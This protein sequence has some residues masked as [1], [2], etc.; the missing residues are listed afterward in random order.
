MET[1]MSV[2]RKIPRLL[3][4]QKGTFRLVSNFAI[5]SKKKSKLIKSHETSGLLSK[6]EIRTPSSNIAKNI[7]FVLIKIEV[8]SLK[9]IKWL[10][11]LRWLKTSSCLNCIN[12][13]AIRKTDNLNYISKNELDKACFDHDGEY[14]D[15]K[16]LA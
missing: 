1:Y 10:K 14:A 8:N 15:S 6:L 5:C 13:A 16:D 9:W 12:K 4:E 3:E 7:Y 11:N 2:V